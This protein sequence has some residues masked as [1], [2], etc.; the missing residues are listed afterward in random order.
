MS[1]EEL[2]KSI[3]K[4]KQKFTVKDLLEAL[5]TA[6]TEKPF[7]YSFYGGEDTLLLI[8][9][10]ENNQKIDIYAQ[11][12][13]QEI[14]KDIINWRDTTKWR[15]LDINEIDNQ[16]LATIIRIYMI[17]KYLSPTLKVT[18]DTEVMIWDKAEIIEIK[19]I[20]KNLN[21]LIQA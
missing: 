1:N 4:Q 11:K 19:E 13:N 21:V 10:T 15:T 16:K 17:D 20:N 8:K 5:D 3:I 18:L 14:Y 9:K 2:L 6:T 12:Y 7:K